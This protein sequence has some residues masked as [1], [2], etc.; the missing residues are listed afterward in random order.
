MASASPRRR[1][2]LEQSKVQFEVWTPQVEETVKQ[3]ELPEDYACRIAELKFQAANRKF[4]NYPHIIIAAD[5]IVSVGKEIF[6]KPKNRKQA[7]V[8]LRTLSGKWHQVITALCCGRGNHM[9]SATE[10]SEVHFCSIDEYYLKIY[11]DSKEWCDKAGGYAVQGLASFF[12]DEV[13]GNMDNVIGFPFK[14]FIRLLHEY[15]KFKSGWR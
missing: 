10:V 14:S 9:I 8:F 3:G 15:K 4:P 13:K 12:V 7:E 1:F 11:L 6:G 5:T 2:F